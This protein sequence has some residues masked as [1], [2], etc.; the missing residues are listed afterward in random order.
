[1]LS[2]HTQGIAKY[3][4]RRHGQRRDLFGD[5]PFANYGYW[6]RPGLT[7]AQASEAMAALVAASAGL[8]PG[9][10]VLDVG[11][12]YGA[13]AVVYA[14]R[15]APDSIVGIDVTPTRIEAGREYVAQCGFEQVIDLRLGDATRLALAD[16]EFDKLLAVECAF[17]FDTRRDFFREAAR[18]LKPAGVLALTDLIPKR[19]VDLQ[20]YLQEENTLAADIDMYNRANAYDADMYA[21]YLREAGFGDIRIESMTEW[22]L[23]RFVPELHQYADRQTDE[24][25]EK[26]HRHADKLQRIIDLGEDY[27]LVTARKNAQAK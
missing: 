27:V 16:A 9:D 11:C 26:I 18:V 1:M 17:H 2:A 14:E 25:F 22:T 6:T 12:G 24:T 7:M 19:G 13:C 10:R 8:G 5:R 23:A 4:T 3:Y 21:T 20:A 15:F